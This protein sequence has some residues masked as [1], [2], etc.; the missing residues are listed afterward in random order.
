MTLTNL[1]P[2]APITS[3]V[4][5]VLLSVAGQLTRFHLTYRPLRS[6]S[7]IV[8]LLVTTLCV[9]PLYK[10]S[11]VAEMSDHSYNRRGPKRGGAAVPLSQRREKLGPRLTQYGLGRGLLPYQVASS[12]IQPVG[13]NRHGPKIGGSA[14]FAFLWRE[15]GPR[16][17]QCRLGRGL[18]SY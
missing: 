5:C 14:R 18:P 9:L 13:H 6:A 12:A 10:S 7:A 11:A 3:L 1:S 17:T 4:K 16:L 15:Q 8:E 2:H